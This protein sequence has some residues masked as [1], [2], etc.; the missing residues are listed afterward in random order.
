MVPKLWSLHTNTVINTQNPDGIYWKARDLCIYNLN[1]LQSHQSLFW[2]MC[3]TFFSREWMCKIWSSCLLISKFI[4]NKETI[5]SLTVSFLR[6]VF[7]YMNT[8]I[9]LLLL[10]D[11]EWPSVIRFSIKYLLFY[12]HVKQCFSHQLS[13]LWHQIFQ[14]SVHFETLI[15]WSIFGW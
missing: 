14:L 4:H 11:L 6:I 12:T 13:G 7:I 3:G 5:M 9:T 10:K 2:Q 8:A 15:C 1:K